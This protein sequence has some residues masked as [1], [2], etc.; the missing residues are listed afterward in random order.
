[1]TYTDGANGPAPL[2]ENN[3]IFALHTS[4]TKNVCHNICPCGLYFLECNAS[5]HNRSI[6]SV[7]YKYSME[8]KPSKGNDTDNIYTDDTSITYI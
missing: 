7:Q 5:P 1:M 4:H 8:S 3:G 2:Q 6:L